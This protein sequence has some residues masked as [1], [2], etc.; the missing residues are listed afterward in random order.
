MGAVQRP[1]IPAAQCASWWF[2]LTCRLKRR[3]K[4]NRSSSPS[5]CILTKAVRAGNSCDGRR[6]CDLCHHD[7]KWDSSDIRPPSPTLLRSNVI[8]E[9]FSLGPLDFL[10]ENVTGYITSQ[11]EKQKNSLS[12][13]WRASGYCFIFDLHWKNSSNLLCYRGVAKTKTLLLTH[14]QVTLVKRT[15]GPSDNSN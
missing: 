12:R 10:V 1:F 6:G 7:G 8:T 14:V 13:S 3:T 2:T 15:S 5:L 11:D 4:G 9:R